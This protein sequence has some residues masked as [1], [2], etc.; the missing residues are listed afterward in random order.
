MEWQ[1]NQKYKIKIIHIII[2]QISFKQSGLFVKDNEFCKLNTTVV[3]KGIPYVQLQTKTTIFYI[4]INA[5]EIKQLHG[6][7]INHK[8]NGLGIF[9]VPCECD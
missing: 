3:Y 1:S 9:I 5:D 2:I 4:K 8:R 6:H 7:E